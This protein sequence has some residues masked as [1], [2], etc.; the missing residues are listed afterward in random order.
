[1]NE[2]DKIGKPN[3]QNNASMT[4]HGDKPSLAWYEEKKE[5]NNKHWKCSTIIIKSVIN[6]PKKVLI[7]AEKWKYY[8]IISK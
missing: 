1:M 8:Q 2:S 3:Q 5:S 7:E 6:E 4:L